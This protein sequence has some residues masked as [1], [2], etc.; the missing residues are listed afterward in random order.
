VTKSS[1]PGGALSTLRMIAGRG[2]VFHDTNVFYLRRDDVDATFAIAQGK[3][4]EL[5][6][7]EFSP[8]SRPPASPSL[9]PPP[10]ASR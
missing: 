10:P 6:E 1:A 4:R 7:M 8:P 2:D 3:L 9:A 5:L